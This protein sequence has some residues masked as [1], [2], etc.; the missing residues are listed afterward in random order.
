MDSVRA[1]IAIELSPAIRSKLQ[2]L[3]A[4]LKADIPSGLVRWV[5]PDGIHL[6][7]QFLGDVPADQIDAVAAAV[8]TAS[9]PHAPFTFAVQE[10]G[11]FPNLRRPR[12]VWVGVD[13][14]GG[15]LANLQRDIARAIRP[16]GFKPEQRA[17][18]PHLTLGRVKTSQPDALGSLGDYVAQSQVKV[19]TQ[20]A[21]EV[22]LM[23]SELYPSGAVY[24]A[25]AIAPLQG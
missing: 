20:Q 22:H 24:T 17:F 16:L 19:G 8:R 4:R 11:C 21:H 25:L 1:F 18:S 13:E 2:A 5:N 12:V 7:L 9:A 14:P 3:Q 23:R 6:T 15:T 10:M